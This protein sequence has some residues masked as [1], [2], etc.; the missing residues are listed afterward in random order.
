MHANVLPASSGA[1]L[2]RLE[3]LRTPDLH[4]WV[5]AGGTG[6]AL[7]LGHRTSE[8]FDFFRT[9]DVDP[10]RLIPALEAAGACELLQEAEHT[11]TLLC[12]GVKLSFFRVRDPFIFPLKSY[13]FFHVASVREIALMKL[14]A[15][16]GR[17]ARKDFVDLYRILREGFTLPGLFA[18]LPRKYGPARI[19]T[20]HILK[21]LTYFAD[22]EEEPEPRMLTPFDWVEC[23]ALFCRE[24]R[25][26]VL[27]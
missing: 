25:A 5:L 1:L 18:D 7:Q 9:D 12:A 26:L 11:L 24:A 15:I 6:L 10:R 2:D 14:V 27:P 17:G 22:A 13:R 8:D 3:T 16:S 4:G 20:Y 23:K 19:N 21:C